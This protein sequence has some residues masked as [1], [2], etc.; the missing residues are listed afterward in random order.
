MPF[1]RFLHDESGAT[2]VDWV[3]LTAATMGVG[4][5]ALMSVSG[6]VE[7]LSGDISTQLRATPIQTRF[8][9]ATIS[10]SFAQDISGWSVTGVGRQTDIRYS[11]G[12]GS[13]GKP[14]YMEFTDTTGGYTWAEMP[15]DFAGDQ[16]DKYGGTLSYDMTVISGG[17][18][19]SPRPI[20]ELHGANG[21]VLTH[22]NNT[23][24]GKGSWTNYT[25]EL[26]EGSWQTKSGAT[27]TEAQIR[28]VL[29][30]LESSQ[31]RLEQIYGD[32]VVGVDNVQL[33]GA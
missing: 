32:E 5:A 27:A 1:A 2:T 28:S 26:S 23:P 31:M 3:V 13:D 30:D 19:V 9:A 25:A 4:I 6:G 10:D 11:D 8:G 29:D 17:N 20:M 7:N 33:K 15:G 16:S 18:Y 12:P 24:P 21:L 14:G 22:S